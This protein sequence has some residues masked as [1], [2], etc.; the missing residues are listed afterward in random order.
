MTS[1]ETV[2]IP[3]LS[4][5]F[6][7]ENLFLKLHIFQHH[8]Q[9]MN[10]TENMINEILKDRLQTFS[11]TQNRPCVRL[12]LL[13]FINP[14]LYQNTD[15]IS[16]PVVPVSWSVVSDYTSRCRFALC[17]GKLKFLSTVHRE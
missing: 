6:S 1:I 15:P 14:R 8:K 11:H 4:N 10:E 13:S 9:I 7:V 12:M 3:V 5:C 16:S 2:D 17:P